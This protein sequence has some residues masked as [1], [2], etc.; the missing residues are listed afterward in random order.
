MKAKDLVGKLII[1]EVV[2]SGLRVPK[3]TKFKVVGYTTGGYNRAILDAGTLGW[4]HIL[5]GDK[6]VERCETYWSV[7]IDH[8]NQVL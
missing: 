7:N 5:E 2:A 4:W 1:S 3:E 8:I 6:I